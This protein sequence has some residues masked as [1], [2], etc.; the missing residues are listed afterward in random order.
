[1]QPLSKGNQLSLFCVYFQ[2]HLVQ[3]YA[4][5]IETNLQQCYTAICWV[6][7]LEESNICLK[8]L[9]KQKFWSFRE[10]FGL[11]EFPIKSEL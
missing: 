2:K 9:F 6:H 7:L 11:V 1:M 4:S 8:C 3:V 5:K 10:G